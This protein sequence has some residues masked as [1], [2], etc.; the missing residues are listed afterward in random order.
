MYFFLTRKRQKMAEIVL[1]FKKNYF[2]NAFRLTFSHLYDSIKP[3]YVHRLFY[4][5]YKILSLF[6]LKRKKKITE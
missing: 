6:F 3:Y 2:F 4:S 1:N 5:M